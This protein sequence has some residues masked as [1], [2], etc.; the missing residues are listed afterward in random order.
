MATV[1]GRM[2]KYAM[3]MAAALISSGFVQFSIG[4][5]QANSVIESQ[6]APFS[7]PA[8]PDGPT[9]NRTSCRVMVAVTDAVTAVVCCATRRHAAAAAG[10][11]NTASEGVSHLLCE[12]AAGCQPTELNPVK[13]LSPPQAEPDP[14]ETP[15]I[16]AEGKVFENAI[17]RA[18]RTSTAGA[19]ASPGVTGEPFTSKQ[20]SRPKGT[21]NPLTPEDIEARSAVESERREGRDGSGEPQTKQ[22]TTKKKQEGKSPSSGAIVAIAVGSLV[23]VLVLVAVYACHIHGHAEDDF[24]DLQ[25]PQQP[26]R[27]R[28]ESGAATMVHQGVKRP[29]NPLYQRASISTLLGSSDSEPTY[30][31]ISRN[32]SSVS[33]IKDGQNRHRSSASEQLYATIATNSS[34]ASIDRQESSGPLHVTFILGGTWRIDTRTA[35]LQ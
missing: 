26:T 2:M 33:A 28:L 22:P 3:L 21:P 17:P 5:L 20:A 11:N 24:H 25:Q 7:F 29:S 10:I 1:W 19:P 4:Q 6:C 13:L 18:E 32:T 8:S 9:S 16:E 23:V 30:S 31:S 34:A 14:S 27:V 35:G 15:T 12:G